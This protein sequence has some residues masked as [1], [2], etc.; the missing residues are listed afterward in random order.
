MLIYGAGAQMTHPAE[1]PPMRRPVASVSNLRDLGG[2]RAADGALVKWRTLF[3]SNNFVRLSAGDLAAFRG[4]G[5][6]T[7]CDLRT[8]EEQVEA[9]TRLPDPDGLDIHAL[10]IRVAGNLRA[11]I[12]DERST[13]ADIR[14]AL[15]AVYRS[16]ACDHVETYRCLFDR[17]VEPARYPLVFHCTAGKDRTGFAAALI[18]S[19]VG[20]PRETILEDYLLTNDYWD[21]GR[22]YAD[23]LR[24]EIRGALLGAHPEYLDA[25]F[26]AI[27]ERFGSTDRYLA[28]VMGITAERHE[29][30]RAN[31]LA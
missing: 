17:L 9:P 11:L 2:Y 24:E 18:L 3:R 19:A 31:L 15:K 10:P 4:I 16:L 23:T 26:K 12:A 27:E 22:L 20:V 5:I 21:G 30:L 6:R 1:M 29:R 13:D 28:E 8:E 14:G 7:I 25:S